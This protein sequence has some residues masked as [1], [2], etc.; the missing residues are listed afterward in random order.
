MSSSELDRL[1]HDLRT[2]RAVTGDDL[3]F[4]RWDASAM[5]VLGCCAALPA[6]VGAVGVQT[7]WVLLLSSAPVVAATILGVVRNYRAAHPSKA[8]PYEKRKEYRI[9][10]PI[11][12]V[13]LPF[14]AGF[15]V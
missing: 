3:P 12:L 14:V 8:C 9:G 15:H 1:Q 4:D 10:L 11:M 13:L 2:I 5:L 6:V 7:R